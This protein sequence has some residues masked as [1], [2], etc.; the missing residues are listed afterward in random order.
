MEPTRGGMFSVWGT[1]LQAVLSI[2]LHSF[3]HAGWGL[4]TGDIFLSLPGGFRV[5]RKGRVSSLFRLLLLPFPP[6][7]DCN[8]H[9]LPLSY[10]TPASSFF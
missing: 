3:G 5:A 4:D 1:G 10:L 9:F 6:S 8:F 2:F 7:F